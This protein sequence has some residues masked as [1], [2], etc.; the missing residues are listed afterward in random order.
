MFC[1]CLFF[2]FVFFLFFVCLLFYFLFFFWSVDNK[3]KTGVQPK[4][5]PRNYPIGGGASSFPEHGVFITEEL[6][7]S[8]PK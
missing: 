6:F 2:L 4:E 5:I 3:S 8:V 1:V 7:I